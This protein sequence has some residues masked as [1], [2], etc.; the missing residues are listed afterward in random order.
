M[1]QSAASLADG[2]NRIVQG[3][4]VNGRLTELERLCIRS[5]CA[6]GHEFHLYH[7]DE[8]QNLPQVDNLRLINGEEILP[9][10][11]IFQNKNKSFAGFADHFRWELMRQ[12]GGWYV[13]MDVVCLRPLNFAAQVVMGYEYEKSI[14]SALMKFP[15]GHFAAAALAD[16]CG[17]GINKFAPWDTPRRK[18]HKIK[19][20]LIFRHERR[21]M[22]WGETGGPDGTTLA[23]N[24]FGLSDCVL[25]PNTL[26]VQFHP[27]AWH[28]F[29]DIL[30]KLELLDGML[31]A[32]YAVH[33][34]NI[35]LT[36][37]KVNKDG[38]YP[39]QS[40]FEILK[41]RYPPK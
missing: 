14:N 27:L 12:K 17:A 24:H 32:T 19:R 26:Y 41:R 3:L 37:R 15:R 16:V 38:N 28:F 30:H 6:N 34:S 33:T 21:Y 7:Y 5:F 40:P 13:D 31:T 4:W 25:P 22:K 2:D 11:A 20:T 8:L 29:D 36:M 23:I 10:T 1:T 9:R 18:I 39:A 35:S